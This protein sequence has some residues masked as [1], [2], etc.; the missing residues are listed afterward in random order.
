MFTKNVLCNHD[1]VVLNFKFSQGFS[2]ETWM[3]ETCFS[4][5]DIVLTTLL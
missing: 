2:S 4:R 3:G 5:N 1:T